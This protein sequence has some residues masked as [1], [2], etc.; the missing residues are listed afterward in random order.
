MQRPDAPRELEPLP[1][2]VFF[3]VGWAENWRDLI[4]APTETIPETLHDEHWRVMHNEDILIVQSYVN[5]RRRGLDVH[6]VDR[7]VPNE[8]NVAS[9]PDVAIS[10]R[11]EESFFVAIRGD[12]FRPALAD[13]VVA[14]NTD[15]MRPGDLWLP[16]WIQTGLIPRDPARSTRLEVL[17]YKGDVANLHDWFKS[18]SFLEELAGRGIKLR[19]HGMDLTPA[20][21]WND[22]SSADAV[23]AA[24]D[25]PVAD[26]AVKPGLKLVNAWAAGVPALLGP[27]SGYRQLR[28]SP[29]DYFEV[30]TPESVLAALDLLLERP[31]LYQEMIDHGLCRAEAYS[32]DQTALRW[33]TLLAGP[34]HD[35]FE[36]WSTETS[37]L[38]RTRFAA[39][40]VQQKIEIKLAAR[41]RTEG[42]R[43]LSGR[44]GQLPPDFDDPLSIVGA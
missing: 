39:R 41:R 15:V 32:D 12:G 36:Q 3:R 34:V 44:S 1:R 2:P 19:M 17:E 5:L 9:G 25:I 4:D 13:V 43:L 28:K 27:E 8:I 24:R 29:L 40:C 10:N 16:I 42:P 21:Q 7:F 14:H 23:L 31:S 37:A 11:P 38:R 35:R 22:Y 30:I 33:R 6:L 18:D 26:A 20:N